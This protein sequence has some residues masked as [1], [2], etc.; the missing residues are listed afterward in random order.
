MEPGNAE[1]RA[2]ARSAEEGGAGD[3]PFAAGGPVARRGR[4]R[5][6]GAW[7]RFLARELDYA[8][9]G[10]V[11]VAAGDH[12]G[13][14]QPSAFGTLGFWGNLAEASFLFASVTVAF[15]LPEALMLRFW[16][17]TPGKWALGIRVVSRRGGRPGF[18]DALDRSLDV[19]VRG[20]GLSVPVLGDLARLRAKSVLAARGSLE[21]DAGR[22]R[23]LRAGRRGSGAVAAPALG[24]ALLAGAVLL[25]REEARPPDFTGEARARLAAIGAAMNLAAR[26]RGGEVAPAGEVVDGYLA[27][28]EEEVVHLSVAP[29]PMAIVAAACDR[30]CTDLDL[31]V[32]SDGALV[33][34]D[35]ETDAEPAVV[36]EAREGRE[37]EAR[38]RMVTCSA[39]PCAY[40]LG[41]LASSDGGFELASGSCFAVAPDGRILDDEEVVPTED[42]RYGAIPDL[43]R[44]A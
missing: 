32:R 24:L 29:A 6:A 36:V 20:V 40:A 34:V 44:G 31:E 38:L 33:G 2:G 17:T 12:V 19:A 5:P 23:V 37:V 18:A 26:E 27:E 42:T 30:D 10:A 1:E 9:F 22:H 15:V 14:L 16:G 41:V 3:R 13:L 4:P 21:W 11:L 8:L 7:R 25:G 39:E 43:D 35:L 28:G